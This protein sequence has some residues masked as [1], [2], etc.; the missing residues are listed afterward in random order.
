MEKFKK[1]IGKI[2][3]VVTLCMI[4]II[5][6]LLVQISFGDKRIILT[7]EWQELK[8]FREKYEKQDRIGKFIEK[9]YYLE[10]D[11][12]KIKRG[13]I[14]GMF[15]SLDDP[16]SQFLDKE[17]FKA[18]KEHSSGVYAGLGIV[19]E[20]AKDGYITV[21]SPIEDS[22]A[23]KA[24]IKSGDKIY[25]VNDVEYNSTQINEAVSV[26]KGKAG[27]E[28]SL[29]I[30]RDKEKINMNV[31]RAI[32]SLKSVKSEVLDI[33]KDIGYIRISSFDEKV[34][35]E[36]VKNYEDIAKKGVK[37]IV[38]DLRGNPGGDLNQCIKV[39]D[40]ILG[41]GEIVSVKYKSGKKDSYKS[42]RKKINL[43]FVVLVDRGSASASEILAG[44]IKDNHAG[45]L[46]GQ[47]TF[48]KGLVQQVVPYGKEEALKLTI[49]QY[50]TPDGSYIHGKGI[51]P[52]YE[53]ELSKDYKMDDKSTDN[54]LIK[55]I[56]VLREKL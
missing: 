33:A 47:T 53:V 44:A 54:Q 21:V 55:A 41:E 43:P 50:Y 17:M 11:Q 38:L 10:V 24:G 49:A 37:G 19:I 27:E 35:N 1:N 46:I 8:E 31:K 23:F 42:D 22:P 2:V 36:F 48:G 3:I 12:D 40:Y 13:Q 34:F 14:D 52:D 32:I 25:K 39:S 4:C 28:V 7:S 15:S 51:E 30:I 56:E 6:T 16:Y 18:L 9:N 45:K 26:M 20:P 5:F 29:V